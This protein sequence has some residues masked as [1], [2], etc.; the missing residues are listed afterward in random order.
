MMA[1]HG[2]KVHHVQRRLLS[3]LSKSLDMELEEG[4]SGVCLALAKS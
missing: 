3:L 2:L 1:E 4:F